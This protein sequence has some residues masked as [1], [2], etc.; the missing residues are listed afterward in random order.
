[1]RPAQNS[2]ERL[3]LNVQRGRFCA[4]LG[5]S[6]LLALGSTWAGLLLVP[7]VAVA[8]TPIE[9]S[10][11]NIPRPCT[12]HVHVY[13]ITG[14]D[15]TDLAKLQCL[16]AHVQGLGF[17][18]THRG[19][20]Y[21]RRRFE[22]EMRCIAR[23]DP[24]ARFVLV[25]YSLGANVVRAM[26]QSL[27]RNSDAQIDL[28]VY[29]AGNLLEYGSQ[30]RPANVAKI[31]HIMADGYFLKEIP[32]DGADNYQLRNT[33]HFDTPMHSHT[34]RILARELAAV[35]SCVGVHQEKR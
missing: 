1:M 17:C 5:Y 35:A 20:W 7:T 22:R 34:L 27:A 33:L 24:E 15:P 13:L 23:R 31:I 32:T 30:D 9:R 25:G 16:C 11:L 12:D 2:V 8:Q 19:H 18:H 3:T 29:L 28:I 10:T 26:A 14:L 6:L 21:D 4:W